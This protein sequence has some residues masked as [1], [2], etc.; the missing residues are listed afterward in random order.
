MNLWLLCAFLKK[1]QKKTL[2]LIYREAI[3]KLYLKQ[4]LWSKINEI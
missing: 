4:L 3:D 1:K 2:E